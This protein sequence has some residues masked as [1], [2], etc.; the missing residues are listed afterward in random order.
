MIVFGVVLDVFLSELKEKKEIRCLGEFK[1][2]NFLDKVDW[3]WL[4]IRR[5]KPFLIYVTWDTLLLIKSTVFTYYGE[6]DLRPTIE[7]KMNMVL[8]TNRCYLLVK[9]GI[10]NWPNPL[11]LH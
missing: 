4:K 10:I 11:S 7:E 9:G 8:W 6:G 3:F 2:W 1:E 5:L